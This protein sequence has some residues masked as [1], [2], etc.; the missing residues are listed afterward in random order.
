MK[1]QEEQVDKKVYSTPE[2]IVH[3]DVEEIT[4]GTDLGLSADAA[5]TTS[6]LGP[7]GRKQPKERVFS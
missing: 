3:G 5:F 7:S 4:L 1:E 2:L 6:T